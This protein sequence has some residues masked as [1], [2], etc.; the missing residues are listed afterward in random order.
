MRSRLA[1]ALI[2]SSLAVPAL[3]LGTSTAAEV[4][5]HVVSVTGAGV[6]TWPSFDHD[7]DRY[8]IRPSDT[9]TSV[10]VTATSSEAGAAVTVNG[11]P[12]AGGGTTVVDDLEPGDEI[13]VQITD[14]SGTSNQSW[15]L[16]PLGFPVLGATG[17]HPA[18]ADGMVFLTLSTFYGSPFTALVD[19]HGVPTLALPGR[20]S[21]F[22]Q[23]A[24]DP[25]RYSIAIPDPEGGSRITEWDG[26]FRETRSHRL[27]GVPGSTDSHDSI[28][29]PDGGAVLMGYDHVERDE[30]A[31]IDAVIE[32]Q[33]S[34][35]AATLTWNSQHHVDEESEALVDR[36]AHDYAHI[37]SLHQLDNGDILASFRNLSQVMLIAGSA[38]DGH[39]AGDVI[40]RLGGLENDFEFVGDEYGGPCA[41][42]AAT[43]LD[44]GHLMIFDNGGRRDETGAIATQTA[45]MCPDPDSPLGPRVARP[46]SRV[47]EYALDTSTTPPTATLVWDHTPLGRYAPFAGNAQRLPNGNTLAGWSSSEVPAGE[48]RPVATE[49]D[50][51]GNEIWSLSAGGHFSYRAFKYP[52]PDRTAPEV[53]IMSP[54]DGM[55]V[56]AGQPLRAEFSCTDTG[57]S[58]L[59]GCVGTRPHSTNLSTEPGTH[60]LSVTA[61]DRNGNTTTES[62]RYTVTATTPTTPTTPT[63][64]VAPTPAPRSGPVPDAAIRK[65]GG[66]WKG[67]GTTRTARQTVSLRTTGPGRLVAHVR[68]RNS[69][70]S[71]GRLVL[72]GSRSNRWA[73]VRWFAGKR[74]VTARVAAGEYRTPALYGRESVRLRLVVRLSRT[75]KLRTR[76]LRLAASNLAG[77]EKDVVRARVIVR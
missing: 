18:M 53:A 1:L 10:T 23:S 40:W 48:T 26:Q 37:N 71:R 6:T 65:P 21:D 64:T 4:P 49:V 47:T 52:A 61:T 72:A 34:E 36:S 3:S 32:V 56:Q 70:E 8:A 44:N 19:A 30:K 13:N 12:V 69:G 67:A 16:L 31:Y 20:R 27:A 46:Q 45:D 2:A 66:S 5:S 9:V 77:Q 17:E 73:T 35:G 58:N 42:H 24:A 55:T 50:P 39:S 54:A 33:D 63:P 75:D 22:K 62:V 51:D 76:S 60:T 28:L 68:V 11:Q 15:I 38:H 59:A 7:I 74:D 29:L 14:S 57:G 43:I 25:Q 41:Q